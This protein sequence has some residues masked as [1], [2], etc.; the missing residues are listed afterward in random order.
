L[1]K[2]QRLPV[3]AECA[4]EWLKERSTVAFSSEKDR[5]KEHLNNCQ[6]LELEVKELVEIFAS[7]LRKNEEK[8]KGCKCEKSAKTR[9]PYYDSKNYG[10]AYCEKCEAKIEGAGKTGV[11][12]NR[13]NP[14]FWR[15][16]IKEKVLCLEC[17]G[18]FQDK[19]PRRKQYLLAE[20]QKRYQK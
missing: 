13:N 17:L 9:T 11:I 20:Y 18:K 5:D 16:E 6:C 12:K 15:L 1:E 10:Y 7:S 8:L 19:M 3:N 4:R 14:R 2:Y